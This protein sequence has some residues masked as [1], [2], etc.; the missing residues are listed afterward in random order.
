M[1]YLERLMNGVRW[2]TP[3]ERWTAGVA[4]GLGV[5]TV[6]WIIAVLFG[7]TSIS[8]SPG[9]VVIA[10]YDAVQERRFDDATEFLSDA[11]KT[12]LAALSVD[13][14]DTLMRDLTHDFTSSELDFLGVQNFGRNA[15]AG[16]LQDM[17]PDTVELRVEVLVKEGRHW[18]IEWPLGVANWTESVD[19][20]DPAARFRSPRQ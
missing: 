1:K 13:E 20:F 12:E 10:F 7:L 14:Y 4:V 3:I 6:G 8:L 5:L 2:I 11:A 15:V 9:E 16:V 19:R 17:Q 18:R